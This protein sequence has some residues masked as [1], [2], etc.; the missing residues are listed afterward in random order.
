MNGAKPY[1]RADLGRMPRGGHPLCA[2]QWF[3]SPHP[4]PLPWYL[5]GARR[6][7]ERSADFQS[8][9]LPNCIRQG[10]GSSQRVGLCHRFAECNSALQ[11]SAT[12]RYGGE[13]STYLHW[14]EREL[15]SARKTIQTRRLTTARCALFPLPEGEYL[16]SVAAGLLPVVEPGILPGGMGVWFERA[17]PLR[18]SSPGGKMPPSTAAKMAAATDV[19]RTLNTYAG[20]GQGEG[21]RGGLK[22]P[23]PSDVVNTSWRFA[24]SVFL[25]PRKS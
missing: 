9:V 5:F 22:S 24:G 23:L 6:G 18:I 14:G 7:L 19:S 1:S 16:F 20:E 2:V 13:L 15:F 3:L 11:Q 4:G 17:L 8:A 21:K 12:L 25:R 10:V